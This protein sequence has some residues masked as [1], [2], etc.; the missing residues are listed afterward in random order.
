[1]KPSKLRNWTNNKSI[2]TTESMG[3]KKEIRL[4]LTCEIQSMLHH[5][6]EEVWSRQALSFLNC[7]ARTI[8]VGKRK[9][10][11]KR[12]GSYWSLFIETI[13]F[14]ICWIIIQAMVWDTSK[15]MKWVNLYLAAERGRVIK[16]LKNLL[17]LV[18]KRSSIDASN[19]TPTLLPNTNFFFGKLKPLFL[20]ETYPP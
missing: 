20:Y 12:I 2:S 7:S 15:L 14:V 3:R 1:M 13:S 16:F 19:S 10:K 17:G 18:H 8:V 9:K 6:V 4:L 5:H 11:E